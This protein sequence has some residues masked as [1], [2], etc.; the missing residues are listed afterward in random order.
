MP[1]FVKAKIPENKEKIID[2][3]QKIIDEVGEENLR[4]HREENPIM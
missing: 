1:F 4:R 2:G 3:I